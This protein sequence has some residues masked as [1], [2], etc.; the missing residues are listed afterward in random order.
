MATALDAV[1]AKEQ[2]LRLVQDLKDTLG[3]LEETLAEV[4]DNGE[5]HES[6]E[7]AYRR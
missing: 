5:G 4:G 1:S 7:D 6:G 2:A 3:R